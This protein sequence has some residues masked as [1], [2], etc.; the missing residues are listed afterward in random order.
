M[1]QNDLMRTPYRVV[2]NV[3]GPVA[4]L[5]NQIAHDATVTSDGYIRR[6]TDGSIIPAVHMYDR[7]PD[8]RA[9]SAQ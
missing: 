2:E 1:I 7:W 4:T 8:T 5:S 3:S 6:A 9:L